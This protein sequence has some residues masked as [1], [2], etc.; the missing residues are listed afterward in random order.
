MA[1]EHG[2]TGCASASSRATISC[3]RLPELIDAG[4]ELRNMETGEPLAPLVDRSAQRQRLPRRRAGGRGAGAGRADRA[5]RPRHRHGAGPGAADLRVRLGPL[6]T[7]TCWPPAPSPATSSSA[8]PVHRRQL[9]PLLGRARPLGRRLPAGRGARGRHLHCHQ[10]RRHR[11][12]GHR[13]DRGRAAALRDGQSREY[14]TPDV[15]ADF[16]VD[17]AA[18]GAAKI[19]SASRASRAA[20]TPFLKVSASYL[21]GF[22][23]SGS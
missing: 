13:R 4:H 8:A 14:I 6:E 21:A 9:H 17:P 5:L 2:L 22:K 19:G 3:R 16:T 23:A 10:A 12:H 15:V 18:T 1:R 7:G 11:R 20:R